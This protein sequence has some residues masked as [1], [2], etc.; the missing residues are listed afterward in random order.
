MSSLLHHISTAALPV[1][2]GLL[3]LTALARAALSL[4]IDDADT[5]RLARRYLVPL[6]LWCLVATG[7][8]TAAMVAAG[9]A[10][11]FSVALALL[12][13]AGAVWLPWVVTEQTAVVAEE[14]VASLARTAP[15]PP[16]AAP[17]RPA[18]PVRPLAAGESL[19]AL[20]PRRN[21][22]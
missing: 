10:G 18:E 12:I 19:W 11:G 20:R 15:A 16:P 1:A 4:D 2:I 7:V 3:T 13:A 22:S 6:G 5:Q 14:V 21:I 9:D 17:A 8:H